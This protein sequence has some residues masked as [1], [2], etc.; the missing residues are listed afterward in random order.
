[1]FQFPKVVDNNVIAKVLADLQSIEKSTNGKYNQIYWRFMSRVELKEYGIEHNHV[2]C[3]I[4]EIHTIIPELRL[5]QREIICAK[6]YISAI[7]ILGKNNPTYKITL[8]DIN[9]TEPEFF[10]VIFPVF[11]SMFFLWQRSSNILQY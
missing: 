9:S 11:P 3:A 2:L 10:D 8:A 6:G 7:E 5:K 1:M 4:H